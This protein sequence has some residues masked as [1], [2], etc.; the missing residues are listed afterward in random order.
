LPFEEVAAEASGNQLVIEKISD[1]PLSPDTVRIDGEVVAKWFSLSGGKK[2]RLVTLETSEGR[3]TICKFKPMDE[4]F[5]RKFGVAAVTIR[6]KDTKSS[7]KGIIQVPEKII[8][9]LQTNKG[10]LVKVKPVI[11]QPEE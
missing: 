7:A 8:L 4:L 10:K 3:K 1:S 6:R 5:K 2:I 11:D 9:A